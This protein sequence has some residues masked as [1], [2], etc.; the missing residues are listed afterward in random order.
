MPL[1]ALED[2]L[3]HV[4]SKY[5]LVIIAAKRAKQLMR[6]STPLITPKSFKPT[7]IALEE[8]GGRMLTYELETAEGTLAHELVAVEPKPAWFRSLSAEETLAE[9]LL[10]DGEEGPAEELEPEEAPP[11]ALGEATELQEDAE[12]T[13]LDALEAPDAAEDD[14]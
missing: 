5:R 12:I 1:F 13:D 14:A 9:G 8:V 10:V 7:S 11:D 2:L 3:S 4:D 6:G